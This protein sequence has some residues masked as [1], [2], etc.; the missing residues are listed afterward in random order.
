MRGGASVSDSIYNDSA[1]RGETMQ[2]L[3]QRHQRRS[4]PRMRWC[5]K[6]GCA[7]LARC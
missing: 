3:I 1:D 6:T 4:R 7:T 2:W 5:R